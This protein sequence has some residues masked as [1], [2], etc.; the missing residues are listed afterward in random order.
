MTTEWLKLR[1]IR[2]PWLVLLGAQLIIIAG[3]SG[4]LARRDP[5]A[6][7]TVEG[8]VA[9]VGLVSAL[10]LIVGILL[11]AGEHRHRTITDTYLG[12]PRRDRVIGAKLGLSIVVGAGAGLSGCLV[13]LGTALVWTAA[14]GGSMPWGDPEMWRT[15]GGGLLWN[16]VFAAIGVGVGAL[17]RNVVAAIAVALAWLALVEGVLGQVLGS[18]LARWLPYSAGTALGRVPAG[19]RDG[20]PQWGAGL[21]LVGYAVAFTVV[22]IRT[23]VRR[24]IA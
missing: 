3:A 10:T 5:H 6:P 23:T 2:A 14:R 22:A 1:T 24:D 16:T 18:G 20:L 4:L 17:L 21:L 12:T 15:L 8:A 19:V 13:A 9:H 7:S 11:V